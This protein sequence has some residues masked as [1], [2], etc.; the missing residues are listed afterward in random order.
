MTDLLRVSPE[1]MEAKQHDQDYEPGINRFHAISV[2]H[3]ASEV[4]DGCSTALVIFLGYLY[5]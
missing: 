2:R 4:L 3:R 1:A 5:N